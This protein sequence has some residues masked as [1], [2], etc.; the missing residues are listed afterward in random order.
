MHTVYFLCTEPVKVSTRHD[1]KYWA[2][3]KFGVTLEVVD[4]RAIAGLLADHDTFWIARTYLHLP[5]GLAP[6]PPA[7]EQGAPAWYARLR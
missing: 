2:T 5:A 6:S 3:Q 7:G 1:L 4:G